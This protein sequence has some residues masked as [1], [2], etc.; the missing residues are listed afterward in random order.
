MNPAYVEAYNLRAECWRKL[1]QIDKALADFDEAIRRAP[2]LYLPY[3]EQAWILA[4]CPD[5]KYRDGKRAVESAR[6]AC[7]LTGWTYSYSVGRLAAAYAEMGDFDSA[8]AYEEKALVLWVKEGH[9]G[10]QKQLNLYKQ[11]RPFRLTREAGS[12]SVAG[13]TEATPR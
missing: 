5:P 12:P 13:G 6:R 9:A 3:Q 8:V 1:K 10:G 11:H 4:G 7:E 2:R